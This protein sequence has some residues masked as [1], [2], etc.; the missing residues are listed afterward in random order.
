MELETINLEARDKEAGMARL[1][2][3]RNDLGHFRHELASLLRE[4]RVEEMKSA[5]ERL[6]SDV[7]ADLEAGF[8]PSQQLLHQESSPQGRLERTQRMALEAEQIGANVLGDLRRQRE[9]IQHSNRILHDT[10]QDLDSSNRILREMLRRMR[11]NKLVSLG[12][13]ALLVL[14]ILLVIY[15]K[16][17]H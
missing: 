17:F 7:H 16:L 1:K 5:R 11:A 8:D 2:A 13:I 10:D 6:F 4:R 3:F 9:Q 14:A 12:I 15:A